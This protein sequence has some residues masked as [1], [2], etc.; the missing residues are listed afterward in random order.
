[1]TKIK[2]SILAGIVFGLLFGTFQ[3]FTHGINAAIITGPISGLLFGIFIHLFVNSKAVKRQTQIETK[4][5]ESVIHSGGANH[6]KNSE[7]VGGKLYLLTD[8]LQFKSHSFNLQNHEL[9]I[10][11]D[12]IKDITFYNNLGIVP[13]GLA[14]SLK[15]GR[16]EKFV[17][18][19]RQLWK[20][21]IEKLR[22][23]TN[24]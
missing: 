12:Q 16:Q 19:G 2:N 23:I 11:I 1:M 22:A 7:G 24:N 5:G 9:A 6:L 13:N 15:D 21:K 10:S 17:V 20:T 4:D 3:G 14:I 18:S 8:K